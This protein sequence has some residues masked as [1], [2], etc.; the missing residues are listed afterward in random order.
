MFHAVIQRP[1]L[2]VAS[3]SCIYIIWHT[4]PPHMASL[5]N[6]KNGDCSWAFHCLSLVVIRV[7]FSHISL[8]RKSYDP[9]EKQVGYLLNPK[10]CLAQRSKP[11]FFGGPQTLISIWM[12][13]LAG[14][15]KAR[16]MEWLLVHLFLTLSSCDLPGVTNKLIWN[17]HT[18]YIL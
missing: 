14:M 8:G 3:P 11:I 18:K 13:S 12:R 7:N 5:E 10:C 9:L 6:I 1:R 15:E 17:V 4:W 2:P 16:K